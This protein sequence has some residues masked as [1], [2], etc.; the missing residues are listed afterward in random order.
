MAARRRTKSTERSSWRTP[1]VASRHREPFRRIRK[2]R[3]QAKAKIAGREREEEDEE[4]INKRYRKRTSNKRTWPPSGLLYNLARPNAAVSRDAQPPKAQ[5]PFRSSQ[6]NAAGRPK[7]KRRSR[8]RIESI[9]NWWSSHL[10]IAPRIKPTVA[11]ADS[12]PTVD[13]GRVPHRAKTGAHCG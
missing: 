13:W 2:P 10:H 3:G 1:A 12:P 4:R 5:L 6:H 8:N 9:S 11:T 7:M